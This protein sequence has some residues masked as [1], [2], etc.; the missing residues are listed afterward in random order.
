MSDIDY[1][2]HVFTQVAIPLIFTFIISVII[3]MIICD[4]LRKKQKNKKNEKI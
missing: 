2:L 4:N 3:H 1:A